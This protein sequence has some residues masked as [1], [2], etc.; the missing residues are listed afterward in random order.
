M[1]NDPND[2]AKPDRVRIKTVY[3]IEHAEDLR[4]AEAIM[5]NAGAKIASTEPYYEDE[6]AEIV[7]TIDISYNE[8]EKRY[9]EEYEKVYG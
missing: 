5:R 3:E 6:C 1:K 4:N 8:F 2:I 9:A 7:Y